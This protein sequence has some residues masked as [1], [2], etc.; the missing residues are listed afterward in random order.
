MDDSRHSG[1]KAQ[2][3]RHDKNNNART[4][5]EEGEPILNGTGVPGP[6]SVV[7][8]MKEGELQWG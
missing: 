4:Q 8:L 6:Y 2:D 5:D 7:R 3:T 1:N